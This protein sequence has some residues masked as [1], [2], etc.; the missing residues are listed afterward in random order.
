ML[1]ELGQE[2]KFISLVKVKI[3]QAKKLLGEMNFDKI[4]QVKINEYAKVV[5]VF[6]IK[7][8]RGK[9]NGKDKG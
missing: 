3:A 9:V 6:S 8:E 4:A 5:P 1:V 2:D 7:R